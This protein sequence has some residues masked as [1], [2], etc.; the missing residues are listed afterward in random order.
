MFTLP[1]TNSSPLKIDPWKRRF[2]I[3]NHHFLGGYASFM[4]GIFLPY[5]R[6][7]SNWTMFFLNWCWG[8][9]LPLLAGSIPHHGNP[10]ILLTNQH[11]MHFFCR[12]SFWQSPWIL[13]Y[14]LNPA[15]GHPNKWYTRLI[16]SWRVLR[17]S[18][19]WWLLEFRCK[20]F[21][22]RVPTANV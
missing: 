2:P 18:T 19:E 6:R 15:R 3:G 8:I 4:E 20:Q 7:C 21:F 10:W 12:S 16:S 17:K 22:N 11:L 1:E 9:M 14:L 13:L 5:L